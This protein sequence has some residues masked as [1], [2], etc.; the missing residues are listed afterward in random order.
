MCEREER[1]RGKGKGFEKQNLSS[2]QRE[3]RLW[4]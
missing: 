1:E 2:C 3:K 4:W